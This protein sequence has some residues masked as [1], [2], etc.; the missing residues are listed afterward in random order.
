MV[1]LKEFDELVVTS[2]PGQAGGVRVN[3]MR[4]STV[5][6]LGPHGLHTMAY[7]EWGDAENPQVLLCVHGLTRNGRD[8]DVLANALASDYR[9]ICPDIVGRGR[10]DR[11]FFPDDYALPTYANDIIT[12]I[13]RLGVDSVHW[14][15][16]SM[17][18][19]IGMF[20]SSLPGSPITRMVLN[21]VGPL[22]ALDALQRI[23]EY[24]GKAPDFA[25]LDEAEAYVRTVC[26]PFGRLTDAQWRYMTVVGTRPKAEGGFEMNYDRALAQPYQKAFLEAKEIS[27]WPMYDAI[28]CPTL[29]LRGAQSDI[30]LHDTAVEM[31]LRGPKA[32]LVEVPDVGH[33][34]MFLDEP[35]VRAVQDFL[36]ADRG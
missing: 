15:G 30:L 17:G 28:R 19:L 18:G 29:V 31:T 34:P 32:K 10:S 11:L 33:A 8:F 21:D 22:I 5:R 3:N 1:I 7:T 2:R 26:A 36:L 23:G 6:C 20:L 12:L 9:V 13:A 35:Q 24:L 27:L 14:L 4:E 16:T 25:D